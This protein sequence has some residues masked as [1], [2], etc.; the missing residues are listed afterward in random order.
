M[1]NPN[2][3]DYINKLDAIPV[4]L[5]HLSGEQLD[6]VISLIDRSLIYN[7][8]L[9]YG[10]N[11]DAS[12]KESKKK[13]LKARDFLYGNHTAEQ[14]KAFEDAI[15]MIRLQFIT[16][17]ATAMSNIPQPGIMMQVDDPD[18]WLKVTQP[19]KPKH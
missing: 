13:R 12:P 8:M 7:A 14:I 5:P 4:R 1:T 18:F 16:G 17:K 19:H 11:F 15:K 6:E 2:N 10:D 9:A 3:S